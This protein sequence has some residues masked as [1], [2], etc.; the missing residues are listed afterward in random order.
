M[1]GTG[2]LSAG[3]AT[4]GLLV[5]WPRVET[6]V[7][8][9]LGMA[10][11]D[12]RDT[13]GQRRSLLTVGALVM[14]VV[15]IA[16]W[17]DALSHLI[18]A[19]T[20][21]GAAFAVRQLWGQHQSR[22]R[23]ERTRNQIAEAFYALT[24]ELESGIQADRALASVARD[25]PDFLPMAAASRLGSDVPAAMRRAAAAPGRDYLSRLAAAWEISLRTGASQARLLDRIGHT[26]REER[27]LQREVA[28]NLAP[29]RA[30]AQL[31][32]VLPLFGLA[33]GSGMRGNIV[34]VLVGSLIGAGCLAA[35]VALAC[36]GMFWVER[37]AAKA[38]RT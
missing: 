18:V 15:I 36:T 9:R 7:S 27:E 1:I 32:A 16:T 11:V 25:W 2:L 34:Q 4:A 8:M 30:T 33:L 12:D 14:G 35:G 22:Q 37:I 19:F 26:L 5:A 6:V 29:A 20:L 13:G 10:D 38:E 24:S 23:R 31:L 17:V 28:A 21:A 3:C